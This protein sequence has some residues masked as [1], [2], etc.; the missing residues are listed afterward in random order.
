MASSVVVGVFTKRAPGVLTKVEVCLSRDTE[1][2][3]QAL[4]GMITSV[5][6]R[7]WQRAG[8]EAIPRNAVPPPLLPAG[9]IASS[10]RILPP[11]LCSD[12]KEGAPPPERPKAGLPQ[13]APKARKEVTNTTDRPARQCRHRDT[14]RQQSPRVLIPIPRHARL[15]LCVRS[16]EGHPAH[17]RLRQCV[18]VPLQR[19]LQRRRGVIVRCLGVGRGCRRPGAVRCRRGQ[20]G[21][22]GRRRAQ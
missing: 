18:A 16:Q 15:G 11:P 9:T 19:R 17:V 6:R 21:S 20:E 3:C 10:L 8:S 14:Q 4:I 22:R 12:F 2:R 5:P 7:P 1:G 13:Q